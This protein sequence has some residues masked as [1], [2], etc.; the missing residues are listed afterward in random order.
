M[1]RKTS[2]TVTTPVIKTEKAEKAEKST[3]AEEAEEV[4]S[5]KKKDTKKPVAAKAEPVEEE[6]EVIEAGEAEENADENPEQ[7]LD[8]MLKKNITDTQVLVKAIQKVH[9][10]AKR[11]YRLYLNER[12]RYEKIITKKAA[13]GQKKKRTGSKGLDKMLPIQTADFQTFVEKNY[14]QLNDPDGNQIITEL[15]YD[16]DANNTL[17]ISRKLALKIINSYVRL[18]NL[19]NVDDKKK[20]KMDKTLSKLFPEFA[21]KKE[22]GKVVQEE[23]F[24]FTTIMK[25]LSK[26]LKANKGEAA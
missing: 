25:A 1:A 24:G 3:K 2:A 6:P 20:I 13:K 4:A 14:Q 26:H 8:A 23:S 10:E 22:G 9:N 18:H 19:Q 11:N 17:M 21:E 12:K 15:V 5:T 16:T 7:N